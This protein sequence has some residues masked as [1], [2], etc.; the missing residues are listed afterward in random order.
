M[1]WN[2][3]PYS[4]VDSHG[5]RR[6]GTVA[7][8]DD[9]AES[10]HLK[11]GIDF[12][13]ML[14]TAPSRIRTTPVRTAVCV[15]APTKVR[16][17]LHAGARAPRSLARLRFAPHEMEAYARGRIVTASPRMVEPADVFPLDAQSPRFQLLAHALVESG[18]AEDVAPCLALTR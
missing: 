6:R 4:V 18:D 7:V 16:S 11:G 3:W 13:I 2:E 14:L 17:V 15:P 5:R 1:S 10:A 8:A 9:P 12:H